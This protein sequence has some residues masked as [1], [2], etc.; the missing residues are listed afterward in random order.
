MRI[1]DV[2]RVPAH[3]RDLEGRV[4]RLDGLDVAL[5]PAEPRRDAE[6]EAALGHQLRADADAEKRPAL[7]RTVV[8]SASRM[9]ATA[10]TPALQSAKA[11]TP[12]STMRSAASTAAG[13]SRDLDGDVGLALARRPL[14]GLGRRVQ[15]A[16]T[17]VDDDQALHG[18]RLRNARQAGCRHPTGRRRGARCGARHARIGWPGSQA[19]KKRRS[20][21]CRRLARHGADGMPAAALQPPSAQPVGLEADQHVEGEGGKPQPALVEVKTPFAHLQRRR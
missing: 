15:V 14:E 7:P 1:D 8:S 17:V 10:S 2:Q 4:V 9:P 16:G 21:S 12:G 20:H 6:L 5:D 11:P 18:L 3:V 13:L 19:S